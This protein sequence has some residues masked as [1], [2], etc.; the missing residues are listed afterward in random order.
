MGNHYLILTKTLQLCSPPSTSSSSLTSPPTT[1]PGPPLRNSTPE[2]LSSSPLTLRLRES[3]PSQVTPS[4]LDT[5][6]CPTGPQW[7]E[8]NSSDTEN[9]PPKRM[10]SLRTTPQMQPPSTGLMPVLSPLSRT[11][12]S[13][14]HA[15]PSPPLVL[16]KVLTKSRTVP[17]DPSPS[18]SSLIATTSAPLDAT[19]DPWLVPSTGT[20]PTWLCSRLTTD[21]LPSPEPATRPT[22]LVSSKTLDT[23]RLPRAPPPL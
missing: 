13:A 20:N 22:T 9:G 1:F 10:P 14:D 7:R 12:D 23:S 6:T 21:T 19:V 2:R 16:L 11:R 8:S 15:G 4:P 17:S 3:T 5:T 18:S